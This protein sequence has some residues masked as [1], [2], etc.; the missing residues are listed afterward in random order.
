MLYSKQEIIVAWV[1][2]LEGGVVNN[3]VSELGDILKV[4]SIVDRLNVRHE[5]ERQILDGS[6]L[7]ILS[8]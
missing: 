2:M 1:K 6:Q 7:L 8:N 3:K 4:T 5:R